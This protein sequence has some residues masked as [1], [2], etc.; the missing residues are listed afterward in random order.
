MPSLRTSLPIKYYIIIVISILF[1]YGQSVR[2]GFVNYDDDEL[3]YHNEAFLSQWNNIGTGFTAHAFIGAGGGSIYYRPMLVATFI[4]DYHIWKL[5][6]FGYHLTNLLLHAITA[7]VLFAFLRPLFRN[8]LIAFFGTLIFSLHPIQTESVEWIAGR[9][10]V[11]LGLFIVLMIY[12]YCK[13]QQNIGPKKIYHLLSVVSF[14]LAIFTKESAAFYLLLLPMYDFCFTQ[15]PW[16]TK[17]LFRASTFKRFLPFAGIMFLY[18]IIRWNIFGALIGAEQMYGKGKPLPDRLFRLPGIILEHIQ[19]VLAPFN[20]S[21]THPLTDI[22][23]LQQPWYFVSIIAVCTYFYFTWKSMRNNRIICFGLL[24]FACGL[25]PV[26]NLIPMPK[27]I[28]EHR[29]Y[30]PMIGAAIAIAYGIHSLN[31][32]RLQPQHKIVFLSIVSTMLALMSYTRLPVWQNG[33]TLFEDATA[34][35]PNDLHA[36]YSLAHAYFDAKQ[37]P[38]TIRAL[39]RYFELAPGDLRAYR[40]LRETFYVTGRKRDVAAICNKMIELDP[41]TAQRY[42][43]TGVIYEELSAP[44]T[45]IMFYQ[46]ALAIDPSNPVVYFRM[47]INEEKLQHVATA[48]QL[49]QKYCGLNPTDATAYVQLSNLYIRQNKILPSIQ[50]LENGLRC[51]K[52]S[53]EYLM[54]L[55]KLYQ[56]VGASEKAQLLK[57]QYPF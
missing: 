17:E 43:E 23:W 44:D 3:I 15:T 5:N 51:I 36:N 6:P 45:A 35:S 20:L 11:L 39:N 9:N 42:I 30:V 8:D 52:P 21:V 7:L 14:T 28:L 33:I 1:V 22:M 26:L 10:D 31:F 32:R 40:F 37:Y 53:K 19:L 16:K 38:E 56:V 4:I 50:V 2:F 54:Q 12:F 48:E 49:Y 46:R 34:K 18:L 13:S 41:H 29:L 57:Q 27:P 55:L 25:L 24:W 47:G